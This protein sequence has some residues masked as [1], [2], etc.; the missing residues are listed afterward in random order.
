M[1]M[2]ILRVCGAITSSILT[3]ERLK[4]LE[5]KAYI[6][7]GIVMSFSELVPDVICKFIDG[8]TVAPHSVADKKSAYFS[9]MQDGKF[10]RFNEIPE[11]VGLLPEIISAVPITTPKQPEINNPN[12]FWPADPDNE[13]RMWL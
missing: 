4:E 7:P 9:L 12:S 3:K 5:T 8:F 2:V 6:E 11:L 13:G 10:R 1:A